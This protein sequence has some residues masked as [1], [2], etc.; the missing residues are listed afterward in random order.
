MANIDNK[1]LYNIG[2][3]LYVIT[4]HD[5]VK[6]N[7]MICNTVIQLTSTPLVVGVTINKSNYTCDIIQSNGVMNVNLL[8]ESAPFSLFEKYGFASGRDVN[9]FEN[10]VYTLSENGLAVLNE[11]INSYMSLKVKQ[12]IDLG[13]H[14]MFVCDVTE[15]EVITNEPSMTY[16]YYHKNVKPKPAAKSN[17]AT[18]DAPRGY[19][20]KICGYVYE[21]HPLPDDFVCPLCK[22]P[23]SDFEPVE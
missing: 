20:C 14:V 23:A 22:H 5:G 9:K 11:Y 10:T 3:G 1:T 2:Y 8:T 4:T 17:P 6:H 21:G 18:D 19:M 12:S 13:T 16:A 15:A 7:G